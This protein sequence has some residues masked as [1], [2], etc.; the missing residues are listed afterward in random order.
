MKA[1][2]WHCRCICSGNAE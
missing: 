1:V 2:L